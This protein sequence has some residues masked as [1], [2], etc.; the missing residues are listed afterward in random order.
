[1]KMYQSLFSLFKLESETQK[2]YAA[3]PIFVMLNFMCLLGWAMGAQWFTET[4]I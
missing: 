1:M 3:C 2:G 4:E